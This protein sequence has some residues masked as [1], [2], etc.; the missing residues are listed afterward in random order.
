MI[1]DKPFEPLD[2]TFLAVLLVIVTIG[3]FVVA[4]LQQSYEAKKIQ[5]ADAR[6][7]ELLAQVRAMPRIAMR[8][9]FMS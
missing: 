1:I 4:F 3:I 9:G 8:C 7:A 5:E 6:E 2:E